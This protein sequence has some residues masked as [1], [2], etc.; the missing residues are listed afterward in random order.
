MDTCEANKNNT[1]QLWRTINQVVRKCNN[2]TEVIEKL[3]IDSIEEYNGDKIANELAR[4]FSSVGKNYAKQMKKPKIA[5]GEYVDKIPRHASSIFMTP[6]T[7]TEIHKLIQNLPP[8]NSSGTD[9]IS[10]KILKE[11][12]EYL[13]IPLAQIFNKSLETGEFPSKMKIAKVVPLFK[14]K[15]RD[16]STNY[17]PIS[18]LVNA[19]ETTG[20][21]SLHKSVFISK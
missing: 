4:Y 6:I 12:G 1:K 7:P 13:V 15:T 2:K 19:F 21:N 9:N 5:L 14:S 20:E 17:R 18:L 16:E 8:K 10:N 3:K 11:I